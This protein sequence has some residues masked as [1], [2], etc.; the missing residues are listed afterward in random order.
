MGVPILGSDALRQIDT[1][2]WYSPHK[3]QLL[4]YTSM[5][6]NKLMD[7]DFHG[8]QKRIS[9]IEKELSADDGYDDFKLLV[10]LAWYLRVRDPKRA[11]EIA[12]GLLADSDDADEASLGLIHLTLAECNTTF[13]KVPEASEELEEA[14]RILAE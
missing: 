8:T 5:Y 1:E 6:Y 4:S 9:V 12:G 13:G 3:S 7:I 10:E 14:S 11:T 2:L